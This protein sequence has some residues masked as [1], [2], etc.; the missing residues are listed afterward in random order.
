MD[1][2]IFTY[3]HSAIYSDT[4]LLTQE[5][6]SDTQVAKIYDFAHI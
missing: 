5:L 4:K 1:H 2:T 3:V 6:A